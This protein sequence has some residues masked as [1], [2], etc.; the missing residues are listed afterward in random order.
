MTSLAD[1]LGPEMFRCAVYDCRLTR[2][3][4]AER[5]RAARGPVRQSSRPRETLHHSRCGGCEIGV[6]QRPREAASEQVRVADAIERNDA[7]KTLAEEVRAVV[8]S[9][10]PDELLRAAG[11]DAQAVGVGPAG[12]LV[13]VVHGVAA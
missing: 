11:W 10:Q 12:R 2:S 1:A 6:P 3:A 8:A 7:T 4:C 13:I 9:L 5:W